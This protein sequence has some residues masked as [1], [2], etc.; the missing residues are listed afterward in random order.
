[1]LLECAAD[2]DSRNLDWKTPQD[3]FYENRS[4]PSKADHEFATK[5]F[6]RLKKTAAARRRVGN[7][8]Q[9]INPVTDE[10]RSLCAEF[11][12]YFRH[13]WSGWD[14]ADGR[15]TMS[16]VRTD[17]KVAQVLYPNGDDNP[18][19]MD[20]VVGGQGFL[21]DC[22]DKFISKVHDCL[23][24][25]QEQEEEHRPQSP[26]ATFLRE[27]DLARSIQR[28]GWRWINFPANNVSKSPIIMA[29]ANKLDDVDEG[30]AAHCQS[31]QD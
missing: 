14:K 30:T 29:F 8:P 26:L 2:L 21:A 9:Y 27:N 22:Q 12:V 3:L 23:Q 7:V 15:S 31:I 17:L 4:P 28:D 24:E 19:Y 25:E 16:W 11:P 18:W 10:T 20:S 1:M 13:Q 6:S 5:E